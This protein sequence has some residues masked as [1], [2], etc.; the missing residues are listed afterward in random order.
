MRIWAQQYLGYTIPKKYRKAQRK[1]EPHLL[2]KYG[3]SYASY[4]QSVESDTYGETN[5]PYCGRTGHEFTYKR[6][7]QGKQEAR[8]STRGI[9]FT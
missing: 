6:G 1:K 3:A 8:P 2:Q 7:G 4:L 9:C 5:I